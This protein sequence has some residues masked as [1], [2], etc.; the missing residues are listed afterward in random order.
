MMCKNP[1]GLRAKIKEEEEGSSEEE[2]GKVDDQ[3][4]QFSCE[5]VIMY[6]I[7]IAGTR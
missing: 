2:N 3:I 7:Q 4:G 6:G 1:V 5:Q